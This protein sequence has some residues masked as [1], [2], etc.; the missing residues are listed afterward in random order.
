MMRRHS[1]FGWIQLLVGVVLIVLGIL[2]LAIPN[3]TLTALVIACGAAAL[4]TGIADLV[5]F[6]RIERYTGFGPIVSLI[7]GIVSVMTGI[8]LLVY[9]NTGKWALVLLF[10]I[11]FLAHCISRLS[12]LH[13]IRL[14]AGS[15]MYYFT[16]II[17]C[18]GIVLGFLMVLSPRFTLISAGSIVSIYLILLGVDSLAVALSKLG[19]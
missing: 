10:P 9:P 11:W 4:V 16:L 13:T 3:F 19:R 1:G 5:L 18:I 17:N 8:M 2:T 7:T 14:N 6:V 15:G 12:H